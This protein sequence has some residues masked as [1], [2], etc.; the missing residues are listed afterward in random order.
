MGHFD[1]SEEAKSITWAMNM[2]EMADYS[3]IRMEFSIFFIKLITMN[4]AV[5][6]CIAYLTHIDYFKMNLF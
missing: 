3:R 6:M 4:N 5:I 1:Y 2:Y